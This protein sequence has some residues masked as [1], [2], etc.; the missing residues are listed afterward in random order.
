M[1]CMSHY[2]SYCSWFSL[3]NKLYDK[4]PDCKAKVI[5]HSD[6]QESPNGDDYEEVE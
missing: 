4:C 2:C 1:A 5:S 3:D 6:E